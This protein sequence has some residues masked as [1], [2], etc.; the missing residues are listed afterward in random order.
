MKFL[1]EMQKEIKNCNIR[2][3]WYDK[4]VPFMQAMMLVVTEVSEAA[5]A[6]RQWGTDDPT[7]A[8][9]RN[10]NNKPKPEG[11]GSEFADILIRL[12]DACERWDID[13][14]AEYARKMAFNNQR[15]YRHGGKRA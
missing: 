12:L 4:P 8:V 9:N 14:D 7:P 2:M 5:E 11:V 10:Q 6:W 3:G 15:D 1:M 13:L